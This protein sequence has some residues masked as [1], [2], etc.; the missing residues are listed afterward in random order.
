MA[1]VNHALYSDIEDTIKRAKQ[2]Q[3]YLMDIDVTLDGELMDKS[4]TFIKSLS[5]TANGVES[6]GDDIQCELMIPEGIYLKRL[7]TGD[8]NILV[9]IK[10][11]PAIRA[12]NKIDSSRKIITY[13]YRGVLVQNTMSGLIGGNPA[14]RSFSAAN[15][16]RLVPAYLQLID[17]GLESML[18]MYIGTTIYESTVENALRALLTLGSKSRKVKEFS[19]INFQGIDIVQ[20]NNPKV[21]SKI[22]IDNSVPLTSL[23]H[24]LQNT[25]GVYSGGMSQ[26]FTQGRWYVYPTYHTGRYHDTQGTLTILDMPA[27]KMP[28]TESSFITNEQETVILATGQTYNNSPVTDRLYNIGS[29]TR[30]VDGSNLLEGKETFDRGYVTTDRYKEVTEFLHDDRFGNRAIAGVS[31][32]MVTTNPYKQYSRLAPTVTEQADIE[33]HNSQIGVIY[34]GMPTRILYQREKKTIIRY[35]VVGKV[36]T[37]IAPST[38]SALDRKYA[39]NSVITVIISSKIEER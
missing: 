1:L 33:W 2:E 10:L 35:G 22:I 31:P 6:F 8:N 17:L 18:G 25:L 32:D 19:D 28:H 38:N 23:A 37:Y 3:F 21:Y 15:I 24:Y 26:Y 13:R 29:G 30:F 7:I 36:V 27:N 12:S 14:N 34:P 4:T 16:S 39:T 5:I 20:A 9:T 11:T